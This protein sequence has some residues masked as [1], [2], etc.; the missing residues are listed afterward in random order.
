MSIVNIF[1]TGATSGFGRYVCEKTNGFGLTRH[2]HKEFFEQAKKG[3]DILY[4]CAWNS[5]K[6]ITQE[7]IA[8][9]LDDT[10]F[11]TE[12]MLDLNPSCFVFLS[13]VDVYSKESNALHQ[14]T[15]SISLDRIKI[16]YGLVKAMA[17]ARILERAQRPII[18]RCVSL[19]GPYSRKNTVLKI[20][21]DQ[22]PSLTVTPDS[23]YNLVLYEDVYAL[24][25]Q[26][27][28]GN[29]CGIYN[30]AAA[31]N[32][33]VKEIAS[34]FGKKPTYGSYTYSAGSVDTSKVQLL[35]PA[36]QKTSKEALA[37]YCGGFV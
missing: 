25:Q 20:K 6:D 22:H 29:E 19:L 18:L 11:L 7:D 37:T 35:S 5:A 14:E 12:K 28:A 34:L 23:Q 17:E 9:Y 32:I 33:S 31:T 1:I 36:F 21:E 8:S 16:L 24:V 27:L 15:E 10:L 26:I 13:S 4:H 3:I 2:N 30:V